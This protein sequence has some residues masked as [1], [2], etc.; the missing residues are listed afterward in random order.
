[1]LGLDCADLC[2]Q[3]ALVY[4]R[5]RI[6]AQGII[7]TCMTMCK[8]LVDGARR[9]DGQL[10]SQVADACEQVR[11]NC[12]LMLQAGYQQSA[13]AD[14][15]PAVCYGVVMTHVDSLYRGAAYPVA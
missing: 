7:Q 13:R 11:R 1:M 2:R 3:V 5:D 8:R 12:E 4:R 15:T 6:D 14:S 10:A 9:I